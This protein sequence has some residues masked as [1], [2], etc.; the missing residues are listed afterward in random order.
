MSVRAWAPGHATLFFAVPDQIEDP[1]KM[2][3]LGG[4]FNFDAGVTTTVRIAE[5]DEVYWNG[6]LIEGEVTLTAI[7]YLREKSNITT[8]VLVHHNS[9]IP[10]GYGLS[11]S[12]AGAISALLAANLLFKLSNTNLVYVQP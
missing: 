4:G 10:I 11:T 3:S 5:T 7:N 9:E 8:K 1:L 6:S 2:G 12:G